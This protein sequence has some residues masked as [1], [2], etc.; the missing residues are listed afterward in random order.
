MLGC[1]SPLNGRHFVPAPCVPESRL[2][3]SLGITTANN[4]D[5]Q[6]KV[7]V[8]MSDANAIESQ[9][10]D[11]LRSVNDPEIGRSLVDLDMVAAVEFGTGQVGAGNAVTVTVQLP[12]TAYPRRE[13]IAQA[14]Q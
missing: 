5:F 10:R 12:T 3:K 2:G 1:A 13:R 8:R 11:C 6:P 9:V 14:V 4:I 7:C